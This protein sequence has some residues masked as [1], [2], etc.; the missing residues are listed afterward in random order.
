MVEKVFRWMASMSEKRPWWVIVV[1]L[2][3]TAVAVVGM[4]FIKQEYGYKSMLPKNIESVKAMNEA[5]DVF[6]GTIEEQILL[7]GDNVLDGAVLRKVAGYPAFVQDNP[8]VWEVFI[9]GISTPLDEMVYFPPGEVMP[10]QEPLLGR[11]GGLSD[12][13][14]TLQVSKNMDLAEERARKAGLSGGGTQNI[15]KDGRA[16]LLTARINPDTDTKNQI[17]LVD[18]FEQ[19]TR[20][21]F[22][23]LPGITVYESG[24]ASQNRDSNQRT[25]KDTRLL[26][27]L[28]LIFILIVLFITFRRVSDVLLTMMVIVVTIIWV[29]G[30]SGWLKF[31]FTYTSVSIMPLMLGIDIAYAI[32]VMSRYYEER[33]RGNDPYTSATTSV[34]T[35]G[36]AV[37][38]TAATTAFG[39]ASFGISNMPP[40]IQFGMLCVAGVMFSFFL[41]VTLLPATIVLRDRGARAQERW[42]RKNQKRADKD[43]EPWLDRSLAKIAVLS[44]HHR[45]VVG[46]VTVLILAGCITLGVNISSEADLTKMMPN[47]T[48][49]MIALGKINDHFGGQNI[50]Y[51]LVKGDILE[52]SN[53]ASM[54]EYED[55]ISAT[56]FVTGNGDPLIQREKVVSIADIVFR[57][58]NA[59]IPSTKS[60][61]IASLMKLQ[62]NGGG[63]NLPLISQ[64]GR[65]AMVSIRVPQGTQ[66]D[67]EH[68]ADTLRDTGKQVTGENPEI[69]MSYSGMP[70]LMIDLMSSIV[71]TQLKTSGLA[72][73]LCALIVILVFKSVFFG[74][75][76]TSVV[77][78]S[79]ALEMGILVILGWPLDFMTVMISSLVIGVGIDFGIHVTHRFREEWHHGGVEIDEAIRRTIDNVGKA[80]LAAAVTTAGAFGIIATSK[81][82]VMRHFGGIT[83]L[84]LTFAL[85]SSLLVL[86]SILAWRAT[87]VEKARNKKRSE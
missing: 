29:E 40:I 3:I 5:N 78:I 11:I 41:A 10:G 20:D 75:A 71:P 58:N 73:I 18:P 22:Q 39:F 57:T 80:L 26:F 32:H 63:S 44:E 76:A 56:H 31:P 34:V 30:L 62:G 82:S 12:E 67:M 42:G 61:V 14:V 52:P 27:T 84:S 9:T 16:L 17:K 15:T 28:A 55:A 43:K 50:A 85:L 23:E 35:V 74:L 25:M 36:V 51:A 72:L 60:E 46:I 86:P 6:G 64:D 2:T 53:L 79:I 77:F 13:E 66:S 49:S 38:L 70:V 37:F 87:R 47:D 8:D 45:L 1:I 19:Y 7:E 68:I 21:Y 24:Q 59:S 33:R 4:S 54:L 65:V 83:A 48:P 81:F 69:S